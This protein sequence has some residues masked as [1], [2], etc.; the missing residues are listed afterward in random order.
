MTNPSYLAL[1]ESLR[2]SCNLAEFPVPLPST[3]LDLE[4]EN[5][6]TVSIDFEEENELLEIFSQIGV[7]TSDQELEVL[8]KIAEANFLWRS[9]A[10]ATLSVRPELQTVY[11]AYQ[12]PVL[13]ITGVEFVNFV[14]KFIEIVLKWQKSLSQNS[15]ESPIT[16]QTDIS[17]LEEVEG[18]D[19][20][21][22]ITDSS[23]FIVG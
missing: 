21:P 14:E 4:L 13:S 8:K 6:P 23:H 5:G 17:S 7:Y 3:Q 12:T 20:Q 10:G 15:F 11:L 19:L 1:L 2:V 18:E 22:S 16:E 9:T